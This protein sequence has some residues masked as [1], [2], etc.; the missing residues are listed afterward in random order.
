MDGSC[1]VEGL[2]WQ[3]D[4]RKDCQVRK[5]ILI[6]GVNFNHVFPIVNS[7]SFPFPA[8]SYLVYPMLR[9]R[10]AV[11]VVDL[12]H[13]KRFTFI[14]VQAHHLPNWENGRNL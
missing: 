14:G 13:T 1:H 2:L 11:E 12:R 8:S 7:N 3:S 4:L 5:I 9:D 10:K 6:S